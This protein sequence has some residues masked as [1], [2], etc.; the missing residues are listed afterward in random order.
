MVRITLT[1]YD[2]QND[3]FTCFAEQDGHPFETVIGACF[4]LTLQPDM[5]AEV[6]EPSELIGKVFEIQ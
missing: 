4:L 3:A 5:C 6:E 2:A 1:S